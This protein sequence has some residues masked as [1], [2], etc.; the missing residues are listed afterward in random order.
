M[1]GQ[2]HLVIGAAAGL[3]LAGGVGVEQ[4]PIVLTTAVASLLPDLD[5]EHSTASAYA[6]WAY[7]LGGAALAFHAAVQILTVTGQPVA[8]A[9]GG[10]GVFIAL[11][12]ALSVVMPYRWVEHRGPLHS[13]AMALIVGLVTAVLFDSQALGLA[14]LVGWLSH[15]LADAPT[16]AGLPL[17]WPAS[18][19]MLHI[20][21]RPFRWRSG[22]DIIEWPLALLCLWLGCVSIGVAP[23]PWP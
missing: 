5:H 4:A 22:T 3:V 9:V 11:T 19:R 6:R 1:N 13:I 20:T 21:P 14:M 17:L 12:L 18:D 23:R 15:L 10:I 7:H 2:R 16:Y 8:A